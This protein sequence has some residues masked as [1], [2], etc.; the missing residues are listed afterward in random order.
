MPSDHTLAEGVYA[1][2]SSESGL[3][4]ALSVFSLKE[5]C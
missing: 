1:G 3:G 2:S 5:T 4:S